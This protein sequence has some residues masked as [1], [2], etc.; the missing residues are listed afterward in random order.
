MEGVC[1][2]ELFASDAP[3]ASSPPQMQAALVLDND[4]SEEAWRAEWFAAMEELLP[5]EGD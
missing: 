2:L 1:S 4:V 3:S 5:R